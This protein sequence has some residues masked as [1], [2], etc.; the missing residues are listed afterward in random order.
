MTI[1]SIVNTLTGFSS[2]SSVVIMVEG[3]NLDM[4]NNFNCNVLL[5][6]NYDYVSEQ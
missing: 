6:F 5:T 2:I 4:Y 1:Y 3:N